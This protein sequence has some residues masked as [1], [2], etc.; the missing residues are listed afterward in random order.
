MSIV[1]NHKLR[2]PPTDREVTVQE[3]YDN[4]QWGRCELIEV[5]TTNS[6]ARMCCPA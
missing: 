3:L 2:A 5:K 4:Q 6:M 1:A